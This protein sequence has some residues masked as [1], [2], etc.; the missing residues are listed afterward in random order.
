VDKKTVIIVILFLAL[1]VVSWI[2][3]KT[4]P[5]SQENP[6]I[7]AQITTLQNENTRLFIE[8]SE[9]RQKS[10]RSSSLI[11]SL[12]SLKPKIVIQYEDKFK[13]IDGASSSAVAKE[14]AD[15]FANTVY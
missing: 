11:D 3:F 9:L 1:C 6:F 7:E 4:E 5:I 10:S 13:Y 14:F 15:I 2:A 8:V 12:E